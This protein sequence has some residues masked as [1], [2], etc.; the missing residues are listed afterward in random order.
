MEYV[1]PFDDARR[2]AW[3]L[4]PRSAATRGLAGKRVVLL[5]ISKARGDEFLDRIATLVSARG[6]TVTR[7]LRKPAFT[8]MAPVEMI[9]EAALHGDLVIEGLAD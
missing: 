2:E 8:R 6:A 9:D 5:D 3:A 7:R 1:S 4:A